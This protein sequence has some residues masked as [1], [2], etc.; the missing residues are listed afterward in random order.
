M[1]S[2]LDTWTHMVEP[3]QIDILAFTVLRDLQQID[4]TQKTRL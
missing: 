3:N 4:H 1:T 2:I